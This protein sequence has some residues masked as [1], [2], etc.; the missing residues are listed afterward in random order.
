LTYRPW[1]RQT[2]DGTLNNVSIEM[3]LKHLQETG[4]AQCTLHSFV[5]KLR[6]N[7]ENTKQKYRKKKMLKEKSTLVER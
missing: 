7:T 2:T 1:G 5:A 4:N 6:I 3:M